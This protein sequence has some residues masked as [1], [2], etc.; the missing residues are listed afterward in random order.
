MRAWCREVRV[1]PSGESARLRPTNMRSL[2][3]QELRLTSSAQSHFPAGSLLEKTMTCVCNAF[4]AQFWRKMHKTYLA[5]LKTTLAQ[6]KVVVSTLCP[7]L[8]PRLRFCANIG[9]RLSAG[10]RLSVIHVDPQ[11]PRK[12]SVQ[13]C[14]EYLAAT[15]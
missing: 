7:S 11:R 10:C 8:Y 15:K 2:Q 3:R 12:D 1:S 13:G 4:V 6:Q 9:S 5:R 14:S